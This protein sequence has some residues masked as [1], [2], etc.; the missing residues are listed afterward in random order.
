MQKTTGGNFCRYQLS[1][2]QSK[3]LVF[4]QV[5]WPHGSFETSPGAQPARR[6]LM[7][8]GGG[9]YSW[10][11]WLVRGGGVPPGS[12]NPDTIFQTQKIY[13][14]TR[15]QSRSLRNYVTR[16]ERKHRVY[17]KREI[18]LASARLS[19]SIVRTY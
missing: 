19:D 18:S 6:K 2:K 11:F 9:R 13:F 8:A 17:G 7:G 3:T 12:P 16:D 4:S 5:T 15:F 10:E 1:S 14:H